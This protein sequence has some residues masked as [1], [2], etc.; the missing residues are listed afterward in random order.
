MFL[1]SMLPAVAFSEN[2]N[3]ILSR[4]LLC[5]EIYKS[6]GGYGVAMPVHNERSPLKLHT[7]LKAH[8]FVRTSMVS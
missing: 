3:G 6:M 4:K 1:I 8:M 7:K 2:A 5:L